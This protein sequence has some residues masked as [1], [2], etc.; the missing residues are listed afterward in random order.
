MSLNTPTLKPTNSNSLINIPPL[1]DIKNADNLQE[2]QEKS[3]ENIV[4]PNIRKTSISSPPMNPM[5]YNNLIKNHKNK[6][7]PKANQEAIENIN[8]IK[9]Y[10]LNLGVILIDKINNLKQEI[11]EQRKKIEEKKNEF[12]KNNIYQNKI[13]NLKALIKKEEAEEFPQE[14]RINIRLKEQKKNLEEQINQIEKNR[15]EL[16]D[17]MKKKYQTMLELKDILDKSV[18]ELKLVDNQIN[19]RKFIFEQAESEK[20]KEKKRTM[21]QKLFYRERD[22]LHLSQT[23]LDN[24]KQNVLINKEDNK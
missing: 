24:I 1:K 13:E 9:E 4:I 6:Y 16:K 7:I 3:E 5:I 19:S 2:S 10:K 17:T 15:Q 22:M 18:K 20:E 12:K 8:K 23:I 21:S 14:Y 11:N